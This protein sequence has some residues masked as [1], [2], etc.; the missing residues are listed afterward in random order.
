MFTFMNLVVYFSALLRAWLVLSYKYQYIWSVVF[1]HIPTKIAEYLKF[2]QWKHFLITSTTDYAPWW[3]SLSIRAKKEKNAS[4]VAS[5][6]SSSWLSSTANDFP[7]LIAHVSRFCS[8][9]SIRI[10]K[11]DYLDNYVQGYQQIT[12]K[13]FTLITLSRLR[14]FLS[15]I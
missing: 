9:C 15:S 3:L 1:I 12:N 11:H 8:A 14:D 13:Y 10:G 6:I 4:S 2:L 5:W 7:L